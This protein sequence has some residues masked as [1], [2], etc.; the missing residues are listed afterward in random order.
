LPKKKKAEEPSEHEEP[1]ETEEAP[2]TE[3]ETT[4]EAPTEAP[5]EEA[6]PKPEVPN[7]FMVGSFE[8]GRALVVVDEGKAYPCDEKTDQFIRDNN[9]PILAEYPEGINIEGSDR[10]ADLSALAKKL[11]ASK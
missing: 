6:P 8:G 4:E 10:A 11:E 3:E 5:S 1:T 9:I 7:I 2:P